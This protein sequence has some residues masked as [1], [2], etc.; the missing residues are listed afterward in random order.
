MGTYRSLF[1]RL[2]WLLPLGLLLFLLP[3]GDPP[4]LAELVCD[5]LVKDELVAGWDQS[6]S[7]HFAPEISP[8]R[9]F[10]SFWRGDEVLPQPPAFKLPVHITTVEDSSSSNRRW[11]R[12]RLQAEIE[13]ASRL[14]VSPDDP[15]AIPFGL[16][17][18][19]SDR[20]FRAEL[21]LPNNLELPQ[22]I[23]AVRETLPLRAASQTPN[24]FG[25]LPALVAV[26]GALILRNAL[27]ALLLG[28][29][30]AGFL[31]ASNLRE[32]FGESFRLLV[33]TLWEVDGG[34]PNNFNVAIVLFVLFLVGMIGIIIRSGG[35]QGIVELIT[36]RSRG[37]QATRISTALLGLCVFFDDYSNSVIVG[38]SMRPLSDRFRIAREKLAYLID[39]TAAPVAGIAI[40]STWI[41]YEV[42][43]YA[44]A[45]EGVGAEEEAK[46]AYSIFLA[47]IPFRFYCLLTLLFVFGNVIFNRDFGPMR[48]AERRAQETGDLNRPGARPLTSRNFSLLTPVPGVKPSL[49][50]ALLPIASVIASMLVGFWVV[51]QGFPKFQA[52][53][54]A[55]LTLRSLSDMLATDFQMQVAVVASCVG[56]LLALSM[57]IPVIGLR[58]CVRGFSVGFKSLGAAISILICAWALAAGCQDLHTGEYLVAAVG[59]NLPIELTPVIFFLLSCIIAFATGTSWGSM[60]ILMPTLIPI[61]Y[62]GLVAEGIEPTDSHV[63][64]LALGAILEGSIF[65]DHCSPISDTTVLSSVSAGADH[66]DHVKTQIPY[67]LTTMGVAIAF[68]YLPV[69]YGWYGP[70]FAVLFGSIAL[71]TL[72]F[73]IGRPT[74]SFDP[75]QG[76]AEVTHET[77]S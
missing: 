36:R 1:V 55:S 37:G 59:E 19:E 68:G 26:V 34:T 52:E 43:Q 67:A 62:Q 45:F 8:W 29:L 70:G 10:E 56:V 40:F 63:L 30:T 35:V 4:R 2:A 48:A 44:V 32:I 51:G 46:Q 76:A 24:Q 9:R 74:G 71:V 31:L 38:S 47:T 7:S 72:L 12:A 41:G 39:S 5:R 49:W 16:R 3:S 25:L 17:V 11:N 27:L 22:E 58:E 14:S 61:C 73:G 57:S 20:G 33:G 54:F 53:G 64:Y 13:A 50:R 23:E 75:N 21:I 15:Q 6:I 65:G 60:A 66:L 28:V 42:S 69:A 77:R 18:T